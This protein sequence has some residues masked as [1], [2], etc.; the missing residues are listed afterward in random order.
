LH[1]P[2]GR[3]SAVCRTFEMTCVL[4]GIMHLSNPLSLE[5]KYVLEDDEFL[6]S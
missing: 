3:A 1:H 5:K 2:T 4:Y 6:D